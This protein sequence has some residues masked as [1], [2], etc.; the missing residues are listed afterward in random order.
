MR[1]GL[2]ARRGASGPSDRGAGG[3]QKVSFSGSK[4]VYC[5]FTWSWSEGDGRGRTGRVFLRLM[6]NIS[7][8]LR[9]LPKPPRRPLPR[10]R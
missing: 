10:A 4:W 3:Q 6:G 5:F 2:G 7:R 9:P 8:P 1:V